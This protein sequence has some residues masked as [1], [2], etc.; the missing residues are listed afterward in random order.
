VRQALRELVLPGLAH[1]RIDATAA[2]N[3]LATI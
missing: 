2:A 1:V 3:A